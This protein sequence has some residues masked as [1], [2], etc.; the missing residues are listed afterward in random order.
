MLWIC[1]KIIFFSETRRKSWGLRFEVGIHQIL[2]CRMVAIWLNYYFVCII[3]VRFRTHH[4][5]NNLHNMFI[6]KEKLRWSV[7]GIRYKNGPCTWDIVF[8]IFYFYFQ[9]NTRHSICIPFNFN[10]CSPRPMLQAEQPLK[11]YTGGGLGGDWARIVHVP[12][13]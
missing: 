2:D 13:N 10:I 3:E 4:T 5:T 12:F 1:K 9:K 8:F 6:G 11:S 7:H